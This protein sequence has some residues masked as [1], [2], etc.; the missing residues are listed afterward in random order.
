[1]VFPLQKAFFIYQRL[2]LNS[3]ENFDYFSFV[4]KS[5][6]QLIFLNVKILIRGREGGGGQGG[7]EPPRF[8][9]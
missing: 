3:V 2:R 1:M 8:V 6:L 7:S 4:K 9:S 5:A